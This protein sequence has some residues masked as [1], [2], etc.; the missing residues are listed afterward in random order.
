[1]I[2]ALLLSVVC[3]TLGL[4]AS[5]AIAAA[6][7]A[8]GSTAVLPATERPACT[9]WVKNHCDTLWSLENRGNYLGVK[10]GQDPN[11]EEWR[12]LY[13]YRVTL[14][15]EPKLPEEFRKLLSERDYFKRLRGWFERREKKK[16]SATELF[17][18]TQEIVN[19]RLL[20]DEAKEEWAFREMERRAPGYTL[21]VDPPMAQDRLSKLLR[22]DQML[23]I[24]DALWR[25]RA[26]FTDVK[27]LFE[28]IRSAAIVAVGR[29]NAFQP[30][31]RAQWIRRLRE[32][33]LGLPSE[34]YRITGK[35]A[36]AEDLSN[37]FNFIYE[38]KVFICGGLLGT[39]E[40]ALTLAHELAHTI[41]NFIDGGY[42]ILEEP[43]FRELLS[44]TIARCER[45]PVLTAPSPGW[46]ALREKLLR[47]R[48]P[49]DEKYTSTER[50]ALECFR[51]RPAKPLNRARLSEGVR[52]SVSDQ[53]DE[54]VSGTE[55]SNRVNPVTRS[56]YGTAS[57]NLDYLKGCEPY[58]KT[59]PPRMV[60]GPEV[61]LE[62]FLEEFLQKRA[63][64]NGIA[65]KGS[66]KSASDLSPR[67]KAVADPAVFKATLDEV[68]ELYDRIREY[69][70]LAG[71][72]YSGDAI[73]FSQ[74]FGEDIGENL[75]DAF[76]IQFLR[77]YYAKLPVTERRVQFLR[78]ISF[79]CDQNPGNDET[80]QI[81]HLENEISSDVHGLGFKRLE[82]FVTPALADLVQCER[83]PKVPSCESRFYATA[84][85]PSAAKPIPKPPSHTRKARARMRSEQ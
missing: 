72:A 29:M 18:E 42:R 50:S 73:A 41:T 37:A 46:P 1:M 45:D 63:D 17:R 7:A 27:A 21:N 9:T 32:T 79:A 78:T 38:N 10:R 34:Y 6:M 33:E 67:T 35:R 64:A 58:L 23:A 56:K 77:E 49:G 59:S 12:K 8:D 2:S 36:C 66:G 61:A 84:S 3:L 70:V 82:S 22:E 30:S 80:S 76:G 26:E 11:Q 15:A 44:L 68:P 52:T 83:D 39:E 20:W 51:I 31:R 65:A 53:I 13:F 48:M 43:V 85:P 47:I 75:A 54:L 4:P 74:G 25:G 62:V 69:A 55:F 19:I 40:L 60:L 81:A 14:E 71:G 28:Q 24:D 5:S 57:P 16:F